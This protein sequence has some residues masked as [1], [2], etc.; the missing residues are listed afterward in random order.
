MRLAL[1]VL[2][3]AVVASAAAAQTQRTP[4]IWLVSARPVTVA[5]T[6]FM[7]GERVRVTADLGAASL[8]KTIT[9]S[10][11][12]RFTARWTRSVTDSCYSTFLRATGSRGSKAVWKL[13]A[14]CAPP[15]DPRDPPNK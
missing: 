12:G 4:R 3:A 14:E 6:Q 5:G 2:V 11:L 9:A 10:R 7:P 13:V 15:L 1:A 8:S